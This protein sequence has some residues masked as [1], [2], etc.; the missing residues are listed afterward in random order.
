MMTETVEDVKLD[1]KISITAE[2]PPKYKVIMLNDNATPMDFVTSILC[3]VFRHTDETAKKIML[4]IH[5]EGS[6]VVGIY[7]YEI[8]EQRALEATTL[9]RDNGFP[10]QL[11]LE[12]E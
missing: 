6:A 10:L 4:T 3:L 5:E 2:L 11:K 9:S 8:A 12:Q 1:E 7:T